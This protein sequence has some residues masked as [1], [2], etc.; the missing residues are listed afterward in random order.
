[1]WFLSFSFSLI[2]CVCVGGGFSE[3]FCKTLSW[4][5]LKS[6]YLTVAL[7]MDLSYLHQGLLFYSLL[8]LLQDKSS[9]IVDVIPSRWTRQTTQKNTT[10]L[11]SDNLF[12]QVCPYLLSFPLISE[13]VRWGASLLECCCTSLDLMH[14]F[15]CTWCFPTGLWILL[16]GYFVSAS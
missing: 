14:I 2:W 1:M 10:E 15:S 11:Y 5:G 16:H 13:G 6:L 4:Y 8:L 3:N 12:L 9:T 7:V